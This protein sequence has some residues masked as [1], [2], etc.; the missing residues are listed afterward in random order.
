MSA[1]FKQIY[2]AL[3]LCCLVSSPL[4]GGA[5]NTYQFQ[6]FATRRSNFQTN[7]SFCVL[8]TLRDL[9]EVENFLWRSYSTDEVNHFE[10][11]NFLL[12]KL[13]IP[14]ASYI[15]GEKINLPSNEVVALLV[16][17]GHDVEYSSNQIVSSELRVFIKS[18]TAAPGKYSLSLIVSSSPFNIIRVFDFKGIKVSLDDMKEANRLESLEMK[19]FFKKK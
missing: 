4:W 14:R 1:I 15:R 11:I 6:E 9:N 10:S 13:Q 7:Y 2:F 19:R 17:Y 12:Q 16:P 3:S 5:I 8:N 18:M